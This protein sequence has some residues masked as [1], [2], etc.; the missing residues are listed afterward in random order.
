M[1]T[2]KFTIPAF[3]AKGDLVTLY[4]T[5]SAPDDGEATERDVRNALADRAGEW[6]CDPVEI[7]LHPHNG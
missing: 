7:G 4:G 1:A 3:D 5:V 2:W 6:G